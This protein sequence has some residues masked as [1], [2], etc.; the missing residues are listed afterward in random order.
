MRVVII[1]AGEVGNYL[2][3]RLAA[4]RHDVIV[5]END[6]A[7]AAEIAE[8][9]DVQVVPGSGSSPVV[10]EQARLAT[11][12][13]LA[14]VTQNDEVNLVAS[15]IARDL[16]VER[17]IVRLQNPDLRSDAAERLRDQMGVGVVTD[18]D[19]DT[20]QEIL[21]L[22]RATGADEIYPIGGD[23]LVI[24][25]AF[26]A[27]DAPLAGQRLV[28][29]ARSFEPNWHFLFGAITRDGET[30]I[31]RG[32]QTI[33]AGDHVRVL[34]KRSFREQISDLL[35]LEA[36]RVGRVMVLGGG[37][38]GSQVAFQLGE[39]GVDVVL[40][41]RDAARADQLARQLERVSVIRGD[42][43]DTELL[44]EEAIGRADAVVAATG[45]D[46]SNVLACAYATAEGSPF[47][48]AVLHRLALL[49][50]VRQFGINAAVSPRTASANAVLRQIRG[51][52]SVATFLESDAEVD[53]LEVRA[54]SKADGALVSELHLPHD[55]LLGA[56]V[57]SD[58]DSAIVRGNTELRAG[59]HVVI[60]ARPDAVRRARKF[61]GG[62]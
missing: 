7:R 27:P 51:G 17:R 4:E 15:A 6:R 24:L 26:V 13:L 56:V 19:F 59:D 8:Q 54:G 61:F 36:A 57:R 53:E 55:L 52:F 44:D 1:G 18:P 11:A 2:A 35:G 21:E 47:T 14:A 12:D 9:L 20:A 45:E 31:P 34:T 16:G 5:V 28:D 42:I 39:Q 49:P 10:L 29:I 41:E 50:L 32:D 58:G 40:V 43:S 23:D 62:R 30:T 38:I 48:I 37:A 33:E 46:S 22:L 3:Q 60:F 25:G